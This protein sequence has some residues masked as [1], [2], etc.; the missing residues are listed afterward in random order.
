[1]FVLGD[2]NNLKVLRQTSIGFYLG[3]EEGNEVLLPKKYCPREATPGQSILV[4]LYKDQEQRWIATTL[5]PLVRRNQFAYLR[6]KSVSTV[7]AFLDWGLEKDLFVPFRE[8]T[9]KMQEGERHVV[10]VYEDPR[11]GRLTASAKINRYITDEAVDGPEPGQEVDVLVYGITPLGYNVIVDQT[12]RGLVYHDEVYRDIRIGDQLKGFVKMVRDDGRLD[13]S[14]QPK[15]LNRLEGGAEV[16]LNYLKNNKGFLGLT[17]KSDADDIRALLMMSKKN[18]KQSLGIL[19][20]AR[21]VELKE[22]GVY[23]L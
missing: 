22:D 2:Y 16:I 15:G 10:Y 12:F 9:H 1:M 3:D 5:K 23:L 11:S 18:F 7:G 17:D 6:V 21:K 19:Y 14:L 4:F 20:K 8:Q 13:I